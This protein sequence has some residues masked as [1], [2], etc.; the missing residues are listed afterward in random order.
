LLAVYVFFLPTGCIVI[1]FQQWSFEKAQVFLAHMRRE[2]KDLKIHAYLGVTVVHGRKPGGK[3]Q[4]NPAASSSS[5][6]TVHGMPSS[7]PED[8]QGLA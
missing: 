2:L 4:P 6:Y 8:Y 5:G 1:T 7:L 3:P